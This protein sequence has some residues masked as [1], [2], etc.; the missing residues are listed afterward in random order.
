MSYSPQPDT[1]SRHAGDRFQRRGEDLILEAAL[2]AIEKHRPLPA[3]QAETFASSFLQGVSKLNVAQDKLKESRRLLP[4]ALPEPLIEPKLR[5]F[6][7]SRKRAMTGRE[8][9]EQ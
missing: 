4:A 3:S 1:S 5:A 6:P 8:A 2:A 7:T 9:A